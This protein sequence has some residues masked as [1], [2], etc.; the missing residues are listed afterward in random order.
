MSEGSGESISTTGAPNEELPDQAELYRM[1]SQFSYENDELTGPQCSLLP[2]REP[3]IRESQGYQ[4]KSI[5]PQILFTTIINTMLTLAKENTQ[6]LDESYTL[7]TGK[8][9]SLNC[10]AGRAWL[11]IAEWDNGELRSLLDDHPEKGILTDFT[12]LKP[13]SSTHLWCK[14]KNPVVAIPESKCNDFLRNVTSSLGLGFQPVEQLAANSPGTINYVIVTREGLTV[15]HDKELICRH[16]HSNVE[17][18][19]KNLSDKLSDLVAHIKGLD[20]AIQTDIWPEIE[21]H[22]V[23]CGIEYSADPLNLGNQLESLYSCT[24]P[25]QHQTETRTKRQS[26]ISMGNGGGD[27]EQII[28]QI[29]ENFNNLKASIEQLREAEVNNKAGNQIDLENTA[30]LAKDIGI[31]KI[32]LFALEMEQLEESRLS[33]HE[34][35][36]LEILEL[37]ANEVENARNYLIEVESTLTDMALQHQKHCQGLTCSA[38]A[39]T[40]VSIGENEITIFSKTD[41]VSTTQTY[42]LSCKADKDGQVPIA[43]WRSVRIISP[44]EVSLKLS[45]SKG[46]ER[47]MRKNPGKKRIKYKLNCLKDS[48]HCESKSMRNLTN[49]ETIDDNLYIF[50][51]QL[52]L[53]Y[54]CIRENDFL[55]F[56]N[57]V[58]QEDKLGRC[59][60]TPRQLKLPAKLASTGLIIPNDIGAG[61]S[62]EINF[63]K[64]QNEINEDMTSDNDRIG[65]WYV[66]HTTNNLENIFRETWSLLKSPHI[67]PVHVGTGVGGAL[68]ASSLAGAL[69]SCCMMCAYQK[70]KTTNPNENE[71]DVEKTGCC[72]TSCRKKVPDKEQKKKWSCC[73]RGNKS[74]SNSADSLTSAEF[75]KENRKLEEKYFKDL[76]KSRVQRQEENFWLTDEQK[77]AQDKLLRKVD[78][79]RWEKGLGLLAQSNLAESQLAESPRIIPTQPLQSSPGLETI[80]LAPAA[81][82]SAPRGC[83]PV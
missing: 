60:K 69:A 29:N 82:P 57:E 24:T 39:K 19:V 15:E 37:M 49:S 14:S 80:Q 31:Y 47:A 1:L 54:Q 62:S 26:I 38:S 33:A 44:T 3:Q 55:M 48:S 27:I 17:I 4:S 79:K 12:I 2:S 28:P 68:M 56:D 7:Q 53:A 10:A 32:R 58:R 9:S 45:R 59:D 36:S 40:T 20:L 78:K 63:P 34:R 35:W 13:K 8:V 41:E 22:L 30:H 66:R 72:G 81:A 77:K 74:R 83:Y 71:D 75:W 5:N 52:G 51:T 65:L 23:Q 64:K 6:R 73:S 70:R 46:D 67:N 25:N 76:Q 18:L 21:R 11:E 42:I 50:P 16:H 61:I 43:N